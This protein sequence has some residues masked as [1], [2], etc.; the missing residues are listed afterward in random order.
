MGKG[1]SRG[2]AVTRLSCDP[3]RVGLFTFTFLSY[4]GRFFVLYVFTISIF[5]KAERIRRRRMIPAL[6]AVREARPRAPSSWL[7]RLHHEGAAPP[8]CAHRSVCCSYRIHAEPTRSSAP[9]SCLRLN[10][11][12]DLLPVKC[13]PP[14]P[15][16]CMG[17]PCA[18]RTRGR[19]LVLCYNVLFAQCSPSMPKHLLLVI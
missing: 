13:P 8:L 7:T 19:A 2:F 3:I 4:K 17:R 6:S 16:L 1:S 12:S 18:V 5:P 14:H 11:N 15:C 10:V 9:L